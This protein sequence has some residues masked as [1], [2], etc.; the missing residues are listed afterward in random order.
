MKKIQVR[1][2]LHLFLILLFFAI[3]CNVYA[4][5]ITGSTQIWST[6]VL[7]G[8]VKHHRKIKFFIEP[9][10]FLRDDKYKFNI[11][12]LTAAVGYSLIPQATFWLG[13]T[14][15]DIRETTGALQREYRLWQ[16]VRWH[17]VKTAQYELGSRTL[18]EE[19]QRASQSQRGTRLRQRIKLVLP[20]SSFKKLSLVLSD[21]IF[22]NLNQPQWVINRVFAENRAA[23][24]FAFSLDKRTKIAL[25][26]LNQFL[27]STP[28][29]MANV[30]NM[31]VF[32][33]LN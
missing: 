16:Q 12:F 22:L 31:A 2:L 5:N 24:G 21:E 30:L 3:G 32:Y 13:G 28:K 10:L 17:L 19:R 11:G 23:I 29:E 15:L 25:G 8:S 14:R 1:F 6:V 20:L 26:Y 9:Q 27:Y 18:L 33:Q 4:N 7:S